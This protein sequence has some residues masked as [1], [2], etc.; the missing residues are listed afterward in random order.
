MT[1]IIKICLFTFI[2][3]LSYQAQGGDIS[4]EEWISKMSTALPAAFCQSHQYFR[5]CFSVAAQECIAVATSVT[6]SCLNKY[7][8]QIPASLQQPQDG[9]RWGGIVGGC[10]GEAYAIALQAKRINN[11]RCNNPASW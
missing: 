4:K 2:F 11:E 1:N 9:S 5:Q 8:D 3:S 6:K 7:Q 10:A